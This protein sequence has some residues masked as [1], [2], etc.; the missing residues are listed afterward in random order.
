MD[1]KAEYGSEY[2]E[3]Q[4]NR[5]RIRKL[6]R[7]PWLRAAEAYVEGPAVDLG[8][9]VGELL[10]R[11][12]AGSMGLEINRST[13]G[14][15]VAHG[16]DVSFYDGTDDD[17]SLGPVTGRATTFDT[18]ILSHVLE[19]LDDPDVVLRKLLGAAGQAGIRQ[20]LVIVPGRA[21]YRSDSTHRTFVDRPVLEDPAI[22]DGTSFRL[23]STRYFPG[24]FRGIGDHVKYHELQASYVRS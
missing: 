24:N 9:G 23:S 7:T 3:Y 8:C 15:C 19:H 12:P 10:A 20:T 14:L 1:G 16:L 5:S 21:G 17:W 4:S 18:L 13:I 22:V 11:L 6:A 2:T